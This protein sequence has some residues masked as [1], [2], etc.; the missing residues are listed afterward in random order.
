[1]KNFA[2]LTQI[3][4]FV[5]IAELGSLS[6]AARELNLSPSAVSKSL[7][8][9]ENRLGVLLVKRTTRSLT[10]TDS[11]RIIFERANDILADLEVTLDAAR[12]SKSPEGNLRLTCSMAFGSKQ[13]TPILGRY[14]DA[15]SQ[16]SASIALEDRLTNLV[17]ENF[18]LAIRITSRADSSY[19]ARKLATIHW[20]YCAAPAYLD[21][22]ESI[23][24]PADLMQHRCLVYPA[25]TVNGAWTFSDGQRTH[26]VQQIPV[27][28]VLDSNSS[29]A[30]HEAALQGL[31]VACLPTYLVSSDVVQGALRVVVPD[32]RPIITHTLYAMYYR[33]KHANM[34]VRN[35]ID[36]VV[37]D[38]G[39]IPHWDRAVQDSVGLPRFEYEA[40]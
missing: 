12:Q 17:E 34:L 39:D 19:A 20:V 36:F 23:R 22:N 38:I 25:M 33:S 11:G 1:M 26:Q 21:S 32:H 6:A 28:S 27:K 31:G 18:D 13:L 29:L 14:L 5:R 35:F 30:L 7:A 4:A 24:E 15:R 2:S 37:A 8:Q 16:V 10:L 40:T 3:T 9:L